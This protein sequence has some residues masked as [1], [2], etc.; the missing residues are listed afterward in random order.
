M[1]NF[2]TITQPSNQYRIHAICHTTNG[3]S[4]HEF[5]GLESTLKGLRCCTGSCPGNTAGQCPN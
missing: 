1:P 3:G 2:E 4:T 5:L